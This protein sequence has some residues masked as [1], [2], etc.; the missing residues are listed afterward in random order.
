[1]SCLS[2]ADISTLE[3][4]KTILIK[5]VDDIA[6]HVCICLRTSV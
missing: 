2:N 6:I 1:M 5:K 3:E 4:G